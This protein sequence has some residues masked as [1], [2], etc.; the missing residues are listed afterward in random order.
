MRAGEL[1]RILD[2][3][4]AVEDGECDEDGDGGNGQDL[5]FGERGLCDLDHCSF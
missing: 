5:G 1:E 2:G 4:V 3:L